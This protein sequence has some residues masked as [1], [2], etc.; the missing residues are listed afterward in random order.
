LGDPRQIDA[1][2]AFAQ[3]GPELIELRQLAATELDTQR[4][5]AIDQDAHSALPAPELCRA[6]P[7]IV[8]DLPLASG[9]F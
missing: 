9:L 3:R 2:I 5:R 6:M 4:A 7:G 8:I 1:S